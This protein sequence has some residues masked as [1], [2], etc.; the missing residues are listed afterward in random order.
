MKGIILIG[1]N[2]PNKIFS[3]RA[4]AAKFVKMNYA[5]FNV[6]RGFYNTPVAGSDGNMYFIDDLVEENEKNE[7][8][9]GCGYFNK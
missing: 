6:A 8:I 7:R 3:S 4:E 9:K 2:C 5:D 1:I